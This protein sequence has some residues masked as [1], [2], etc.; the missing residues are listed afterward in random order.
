MRAVQFETTGGP[1]ELRVVDLPTPEPAAAEVLIR[2]EACGLNRLD[3]MM[4]SGQVPCNPMP[5]IPGSE[6]AGAIAAL[7]PGVRG[8]AEGQRVTVA[9]Y[10]FCGSCEFCLSGREEIC[11][12]SAIL[13][14][15]T[16]GGYAQYV[17]VPA[18]NVIPL[19]DGVSAEQAAAVS[20]AMLTAYHMLV[21]RA[22]VQPGEDALVIAAGSGVG[23]AAVQIAKLLG[24]RVIAAAS[25]DEKLEKARALGADETVNYVQADLRQEVRRLTGKRGVDLVVEHVGAATFATSVACL[26]RA[27][28]LV[29]CGA[30]T[31]ARV[32]FDLWP[33]FAKENQFVGAYGGT[34]GELYQVLRLLSQGRL[35]AVIDTALPLEQAAEAHRRMEQREQ[36]GKVLL[37]P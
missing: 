9:P 11:L 14:H 35:R 17:A 10:L 1:E 15:A 31:G 4:R 12:K 29:T 19:P 32:E 8:L 13:G 22:R 34:R 23:S 24:A 20:L 5:H 6:P 37:K 2:V 33:F 36:F 30:F 25:S 21:T 16:Q 7:G 18:T 3:I 26:G 28:R 27:G